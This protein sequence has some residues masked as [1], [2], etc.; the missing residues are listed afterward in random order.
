MDLKNEKVDVE[1]EKVD[2]Q[3]QRVAFLIMNSS[4]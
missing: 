4:V 2:I 1:K 3:K